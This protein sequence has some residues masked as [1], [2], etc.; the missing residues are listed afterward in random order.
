MKSSCYYVIDD[1]HLDF[2]IALLSLVSVYVRRINI[3]L[4]A[5]PL[6]VYFSPS[7]PVCR[8]FFLLLA[9]SPGCRRSLNLQ[10]NPRR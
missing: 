3:Y 8:V 5:L 7:P 9:S 6:T 10:P 2:Q 1:P 4:F